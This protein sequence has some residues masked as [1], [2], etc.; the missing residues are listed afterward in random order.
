[1]VHKQR[2]V[3]GGDTLTDDLRKTIRGKDFIVHESGKLLILATP[4]NFELLALKKKCDG[5]FDSAP[6]GSQ[7]YIVHVLLDECHTV[8]VVYCIAKN[9][10]KDTYDMIFRILKQ[11]RPDLNPVSVTIDYESAAL[12]SVRTFFF[13][14]TNIYG[15]F[16]HFGQCLWREIQRSALYRLGIMIRTMQ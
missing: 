8:P 16:F 14:N 15:C 5:T 12:N 4:R 9:K 7:L 11:L 13:P 2:M 10:N 1:M 3:P 6:L